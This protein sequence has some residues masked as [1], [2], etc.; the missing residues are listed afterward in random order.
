MA[1]PDIPHPSEHGWT[2]SEDILSIDWCEDPVP[3]H[4]VDIL[5]VSTTEEEGE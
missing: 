1:C 5:Y 2:L 4:V 3:Q